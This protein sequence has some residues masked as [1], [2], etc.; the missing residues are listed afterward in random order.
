M[1]HKMAFQN[2]SAEEYWK[3]EECQCLLCKDIGG[4][5]YDIP[6]THTEK[7]GTHGFFEIMDYDKGVASI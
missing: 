6:D 2:Q 5:K 4:Y 3:K 1:A 7:S